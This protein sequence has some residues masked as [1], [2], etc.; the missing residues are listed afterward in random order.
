MP[1]ATM[2]DVADDIFL[3]R[4]PIVDRAQQLHGFELLFRNSLANHAAVTDDKAATSTVI[5][6]TLSEFGIDN[7][8]G[9][10]SGFI[11]C[12]ASFLMSDAIVLLPP[13]RVVLELLESTVSDAE[14]QR[15][16]LELQSLGFRL[17]LDDFQGATDYNRGL[18]PMMDIIKVDIN[19]LSPS[20]LDGLS[21]D[22]RTLNAIRLAEKVESAAQFRHCIDLGYHLFQG[23]HFARPEMVSGRRLSS[24]HT[25]LLRLLAMLQEDVD[26]RQIEDV[27]KQNPALSVNLLRLANSA[28]MG[29]RQPLRSVANAIVVL[30]RRQLQRWLLLLMLATADQ[31]QAARPALLHLAATRGKLMELLMLQD[32]PTMADSA[33]VAGIVSVMDALLGQSMLQVVDALGL[34]DDMRRA[35]LQRSGPI[36]RM[37]AVV[38]ALEGG[39]HTG[40][41]AGMAVEEH[42]DEQDKQDEQDKNETELMAYLEADAARAAKRLNH[43]QGLALAWANQVLQAA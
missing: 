28:A 6:H 29:Y 43:S 26:I 21:R 16:C 9:G 23:Y 33:F 12:D 11:N 13:D 35:L 15:R 38:E 19:G 41:K 5:V 14:I 3:G 20:A 32:H 18:L 1:V 36:G 42:A 7:V 30:G 31:G 34:A 8:L 25:A 22:V 24:S 27:F 17:A 40:V 2:Q 39:Q 4:Q 10:F 37:L